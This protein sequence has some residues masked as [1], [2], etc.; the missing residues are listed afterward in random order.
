[1]TV[2]DFGAGRGAF[3]SDNR[4]P[5][6][7]SL[8]SLR[9][10]VARVIGVDI[11]SAVQANRGVDEA[12]VMPITP[13]GIFTIP[14][15]DMSVDIVVS[16]YTFEHVSRPEVLAK[17]L[18]RVIKPGGWICARTPNRW[19]YIGL[20]S[21]LVPNAAHSL[22]LRYLQP[23]RKDHDVFPT[24]YRMNDRA[25]LGRLF[26]L[27]SFVNY[28][29]LIH[30]E[31]AYAGNSKPLWFLFKLLERFTPKFARPVLLVFIHKTA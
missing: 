20:A 1:M 19:G 14:V 25:T 17:E 9:G 3:L 24:V 12:L 10:K 6:K 22:F 16:D 26:P 2:L 28:S 7:R 15:P 31:P 21:A 5:Y 23:Y 13:D 8:R 29:Y 18:D 11:D 4:S 27:P 30:V